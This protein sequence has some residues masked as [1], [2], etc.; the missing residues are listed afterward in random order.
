MRYP[1]DVDAGPAPGGQERP[2]GRPGL[3]WPRA[4]SNEQP[5]GEGPAGSRADGG[6]ASAGDPG[7]GYQAGPYADVGYSDAGYGD[8]LE[9]GAGPADGTA[10][11][12]GAPS[13]STLYGAA[14]GTAG[15]GPGRGFPPAPGPAAPV[16][17]AG[18]LSAWNQASGETRQGRPGRV[19]GND[20]WPLAA[21]AEHGYAEP[22]Y[23]V[24]AVSD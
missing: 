16:Y 2:P 8:V 7:G 12:A 3:S 4:G 24:L 20:A 23:S 10:R 6:Y 11:W 14:G 18:Q 15:K 17:P 21:S 22:D 5:G 1:G 19:A 9:P 13:A